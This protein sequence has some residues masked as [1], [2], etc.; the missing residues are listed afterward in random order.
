MK[1]VI[2]VINQKGGVG[3]TTT[4]INLATGLSFAGNKVLL[5]DID[6]QANTTIGMGLEPHKLK[7]TIQD[8]LLHKAKITDVIQ[9]TE[10]DNLDIAPAYI[11]LDRAEGLLTQ[12]PFK[13]IRLKK[14]IRNLD[15][16]YIII[17]CR[18]SLGTLTYNALFA[19]SLLLVPCDFSR[20]ALDGLNDLM[21]TISDIKEDMD[22]GLNIK[23]LL[24]KYD[25]RSK[26]TNEW[27]FEA[28][29]PHKEKILETTIRH[30][31]ALN[32]AHIANM[33]IFSFNNK[34]HGSDDYYKLTKEI[35]NICQT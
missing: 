7:K 17:D 22:N 29:E 5:I 12:E 4:S 24:T 3:K 32:Q 35:Q 1:N 30:N 10:I 8:A 16:D 28:I 2:A 13:E 18:P 15:Y 20:Y 31:Q 21:A 26:V 11:H 14:L 33:N 6:P 34:S 27:F 9:K 25:S 23:V 19:C